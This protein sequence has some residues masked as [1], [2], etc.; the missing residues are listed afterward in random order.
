MPVSQCML[1]FLSLAS[2]ISNL[3][4]R[5]SASLEIPTREVQ[6]AV[7]QRRNKQKPSLVEPFI[8]SAA[9]GSSDSEKRSGSVRRERG[10]RSNACVSGGEPSSTDTDGSLPRGMST[11]GGYLPALTPRRK[12]ISEEA[13]K[14]GLH[15]S[16]S[17]T[18]TTS[19][20]SSMSFPKLAS[21]SSYTGTTSLSS[22][23]S[24]SRGYY[25]AP[26]QLTP[27]LRQKRD[28]ER[29]FLFTF[30]RRLGNKDAHLFSKRVGFLSIL[31][32]IQGVTGSSL[33]T[34]LSVAT[35]SPTAAS[36]QPGPATAGGALLSPR[37]SAWKRSR[38]SMIV[39]SSSSSASFTE[40]PAL[41]GMCRCP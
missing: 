20:V 6:E 26:I 16:S 27:A 11:S 38:A 32:A 21:S 36:S 23:S 39:L 7:D 10:E 13:E 3:W 4:K 14:I 8:P 18:S 17:S 41:G 15:N 22:S 25:N 30:S 9:D 2:S 28:F 31:N 35:P 19:P 5:L 29:K 33:S 24:G 37:H 12:L 40:A 1:T 34:S